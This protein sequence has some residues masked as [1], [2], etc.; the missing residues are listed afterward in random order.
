MMMV[1]D[2]GGLKSKEEEEKETERLKAW[3]QGLS[4]TKGRLNVLRPQGLG[5]PLHTLAVNAPQYQVSHHRPLWPVTSASNKNPSII[6]ALKNFKHAGPSL[7]KSNFF[8]ALNK[9]TH[10][11]GRRHHETMSH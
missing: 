9:K 7:R 8:G 4:T 3:E 2:A 1:F 5:H 10:G 11:Q 6:F